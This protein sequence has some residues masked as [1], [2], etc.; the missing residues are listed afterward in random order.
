[1]FFLL[2]FFKNINVDIYSIAT[3]VGYGDSSQDPQS[4]MIPISPVP[5]ISE[6]WSGE[7]GFPNLSK[8]QLLDWRIKNSFQ[9]FQF[10]IIIQ[11]KNQPFI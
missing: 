10:P 1:M 9:N 6:L 4:S 8:F 3:I 2:F 7:S 5:M 11:M